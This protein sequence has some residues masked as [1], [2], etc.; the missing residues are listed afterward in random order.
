MSPLGS[1]AVRHLTRREAVTLLELVHLCALCETV[2]DL[3]GIVDGLK[4][5]VPFEYFACLTAAMEGG[6][7]AAFRLVD[8]DYD[9]EWVR[10]YTERDYHLVD[11]VL[12]ENFR[13]LGVQYW[14]DTYRKDP[15]DREFRGA[16]ERFGLGSGYTSGARN[17][18]GS[19]GGLFSFAGRD[20]K[21]SVR[22]VAVLEVITPHLYLAVER[23]GSADR[24]KGVPALTEREREVLRWTTQGKTEWETAAILRISE[25]TVKFHMKNV[26]LKLN[27]V[28]RAHAAAVA[29][30]L[31]L[32]EPA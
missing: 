24:L 7:P 22:T 30:G 18:S 16:A 31:G 21:R 25:R 6:V 3:R 12:K 28:S 4:G 2:E 11:P 9:P 13:S 14:A 29:S 5:L 1:H 32:A 8:S 17:L 26:K 20:V 19:R 27:A 23:M 15:P 10:M